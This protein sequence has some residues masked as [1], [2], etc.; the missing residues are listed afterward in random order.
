MKKYFGNEK[1]NQNNKLNPNEIGNK[2]F[3][4]E[5]IY[6][7]YIEQLSIF[8]KIQKRKKFNFNK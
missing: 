3:K 7:S 6:N 8:L 4:F 2:K 1:I 5:M